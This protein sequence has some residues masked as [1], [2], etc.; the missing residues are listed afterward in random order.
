RRTRFSRLTLRILAVNVL[1]L[2]ILV[3]GLFYLDE[4]RQG[5]IRAQIND[6]RINAEVIAGALAE[7][8]TTGP[9]AEQVERSAAMQILTR[10]VVPADSR[11]RLFAKDGHLLVDSRDL[12]VGARIEAADLPRHGTLEAFLYWLERKFQKAVDLVAK[13]EVLPLY[14]EALEQKAADYPEVLSALE[15]EPAV[16]RRASDTGSTVITV[17]VPVQ[18]LHRVLGALLVSEDTAEIDRLMEKERLAILEIFTLA[19][20]VTLLLSVFLSG[21]IARP[22]RLLS[23]AAD[24]VRPGQG[25]NVSIPDFS[26]RRDEIGLLSRSLQEMTAS[27]FRQIDAVEAFAADVSHEMKNPI[28][29]L[30]SALETLRR[31]KDPETREKLISIMENDVERLNRLISDI[32][33]ATRLDAEMARSRTERI[34]L[35]EILHEIVLAYAATRKPDQ[36]EIVL[37]LPRSGQGEQQPVMIEGFPRALGQ[38]MRNLIDNALT[39]SPPDKP[40]T[41]RLHPGN[42]YVEITVEDCGPGIPPD[43]LEAIFDRFY[44]ERPAGEAFGKHSG[45]GLN[46]S[47]QIV[48]AHG[49]EIFAENRS[50][51]DPDRPAGARFVIRLPLP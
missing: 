15:G 47:R 6:L 30:R 29:S 42:N 22:I 51:T 36:A 2:G 46:I 48:E 41:I 27:L 45:L 8:A 49:G 4:F 19:F 25:R 33:A 40:I 3:G 1:A 18:R 14:H 50:G 7:A 43:K 16:M 21:T 26:S 13:K 32:S 10:L 20:G 39:F 31:A 5:L 17:A 12:A 28:T 35:A 44:S 37:D 9:D 34:D 23:A 38:V 24:R 11:A